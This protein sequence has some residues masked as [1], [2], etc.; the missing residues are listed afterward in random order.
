M[1]TIEELSKDLLIKQFNEFKVE[2]FED[3]QNIVNYLKIKMDAI[4][5]PFLEKG[6]DDLGLSVRAYNCLMVYLQRNELYDRIKETPKVKHIVNISLDDFKKI[7]N[8][9]HKSILEIQY[10]LNEHGYDFKS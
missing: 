9:G 4:K 5:N 3:L 10:C 7:R 1:K 2:T 8:V 6:I